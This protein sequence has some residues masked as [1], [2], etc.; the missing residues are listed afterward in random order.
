[1]VARVFTFFAKFIGRFQLF[2]VNR[3]QLVE[4]YREIFALVDSSKVETEVARLS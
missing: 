1:M 2:V 4:F 3:D